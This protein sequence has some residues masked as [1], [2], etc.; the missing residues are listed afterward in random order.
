MPGCDSVK[1]AVRVRPFSKVLSH[2]VKGLNVP[3]KRRLAM[4]NYASLQADI[5]FMQETHFRSFHFSGSQKRNGVSILREVSFTLKTLQ[6]SKALGPDGF[7][8]A[9]YKSFQP[10]LRPH[11]T[12]LFNS[13]LHGVNPLSEMLLAQIVVIPKAGKDLNFCSN[14]RLI[15]L[16]SFDIK[17]FAKILAIRL[18]KLLPSLIHPDHVGFV[19]GREAPDNIHWALN[20]IQ[21][22]KDAGSKCIISMKDNCTTICDPRNPAHEKT[23]NFDLAYW[24][25]NGYLKNKDGTLI[26]NGSDSRYADQER[27]FQ[28]LG[29]G[30]LNN[31][32]QGYNATLLAYGQTGSGKS[33]SM[34]GYGANR[35]IIPVVC[36]ELFRAIENYQDKSR[37]YQVTF[38]MLEIYNEQVTDLL[39]K[40]K[41]SGGLKVREDQHQGFYVDGLKLVPCESY[42]Q[43]ER[44]ME[45]GK[46]IRTTATTSMN[47]SSSRSHMVITIQFKQ[48]F[49]EE[50]ITKQSSINLVDLAGSE[51]QKSSGSEGDRLRE[52]TCV[53][54]SLTTLGNV[55]SALA[56]AAMG[57]KILHIP[58]R[59]SV[60]T[61]LLQ[62]ALGGN[63]RTVMIAAISPADLCYE[64][65]LSTLRYAERAKKIKNKAVINAGPTERL[66]K[67]L[68][69]EN[70]QLLSRLAG[71]GNPGKRVEHET[72]ELRRLLTKNELRIQAIQMTWE[73]QLHEARKEWEQQYAAITQERR[74]M[75]LYPYLL[76]INEDPQLSGVLKHFIHDGSSDIGQ[77][78]SNAIT[79]RGL[80]ILPK[81]ATFINTEHKVVVKPYGKAKVIV[82]GVPIVMNTKLQHLDRIILGSNSGYLFIGFPAERGSEDI[83][84]F[85]YDFFQSELAAAEGFSVDNL[86]AVHNKDGKRDPSV[87]AV[88]HDYIKL[89]P[90]VAEA[91][92]M[93]EEL[94]KDLWFEL[95][96][97]N[98]AL[99]DSRGYDLQ[100]E[101]MVKVINKSTHQVWIWSKSKFIN[102][103]FLMEELY[104]R[105]LN[106]AIALDRESDPFWDP[107]EVIHLGSAHIW[108]QSLAYCMKLEEQ[109]ELLNSEGTEEAILVINITPCSSIERP[110]GEEDIVIDPLELLGRKIVFQIHIIQCLGVRWLKDSTKRGIQIGYRFYDVSHCLYTKPVWKNVNPVIEHKLQFVTLNVSNELLNYL[111]KNAL[112]VDLWGLQEGCPELDWSLPD[113]DCTSE[114]EP[115][116]IDSVKTLLSSSARVD[117]NS[118]LSELYRKLLKLEQETEQLRD[119]NR[120]LRE[121]NIFLKESLKKPD[122]GKLQSS[123]NFV[124]VPCQGSS[125]KNAHCV[126]P[127]KEGGRLSRAGHRTSYDADFAKALKVFYQSMNTIRGHFLRLKH[128]KPPEEESINMLRLFTEKQSQMFK[129]FW[130]QL[131]CCIC[132]LK[133][134][135]A[136]IVKKKRETLAYSRSGH[137][138]HPAAELV[139]GVLPP[140]TQTRDL[141]PR[142]EDALPF[143]GSLL[144]SPVLEDP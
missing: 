46:K 119:I 48:I 50:D 76:N 124:T 97:K 85:D 94:M 59:D 45:Q 131:E 141:L 9:C 113:T 63:S 21:R 30:V 36:E 140:R 96:V 75:Q 7:T 99:T 116:L 62:S 127:S 130:Q 122:A 26:P 11:L 66:I 19:P 123:E 129:D 100:K 6:S 84:R 109:T 57:K 4:R 64:E 8:A 24:S 65:T 3:Q 42:A 61:K 14:Y 142:E 32:W 18:S 40:T 10:T 20:L 81:H 86:G 17:L 132:K 105:F 58:Y 108:L 74:L 13:F 52:G 138:I 133:N 111:Q 115:I 110:F 136:A 38:S 34:I 112:V 101:I 73:H 16:F 82:N 87:L 2:N 139:P 126:V 41:K 27:V 114:E 44:L 92:Q 1:V 117:S 5:I 90:L 43:I 79:L 134:D 22:E 29:Q 71:L 93:S 47:S 144:E 135:V 120:A 95:K 88:F 104:Q 128:Y 118:H 67:E 60:L 125:A 55:I 15:S 49:L 56:E 107:V 121:E 102:R 53:N 78:A 83:S 91:N 51:R 69:A 77:A 143:K 12:T 103:K 25:H 70:D 54:L 89:M 37:R 106:G 23:F 33:Y 35:G 39:S 28:D 31:A 137:C 68:K 72:K 80:G 98:L